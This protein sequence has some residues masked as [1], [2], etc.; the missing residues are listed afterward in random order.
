MIQMAE[1][2]ILQSF[3]IVLLDCLFGMK[4][5][6]TKIEIQNQSTFDINRSLELAHI[7]ATLIKYENIISFGQHN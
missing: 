4:S 2:L 5:F 7:L 3:Y 6:C 1:V